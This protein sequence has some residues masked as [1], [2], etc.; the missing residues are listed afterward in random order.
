VDRL[1]PPE[2]LITK[3]ERN[4]YP[5]TFELEHR[6]LQA[7]TDALFAAGFLIEQVQELGEPDPD[8]KWSRIPLFLHVRA[9]ASQ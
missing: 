8:D 2:H 3:A 5:M 7:Y 4:G 6:P 9:L 1:G